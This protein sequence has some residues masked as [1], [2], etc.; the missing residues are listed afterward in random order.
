MTARER[1]S[2]GQLSGRCCLITGAAGALGLATVRRFAA[3]GAKIVA[4]DRVTPDGGW[5]SGVIAE[6]GDGA[7]PEFISD[8]AARH[9][10]LDTLVTFAA[11]SRGGTTE[12]TTPETWLEVLQVN[13][14]ATAL[15]IG[16][17][18]P[19]M[20]AAGRG[21]I[22][23]VGSQ[24]AQSGAAGN[25]SYIASK[26]AVAALTRAVAVENA[27]RGIRCNCLIPGAIESPLLR[28]SFAR[29][30]DP[31]TVESKSLAR[32]PAGRFGAP[33]EVAAA[34]LFLAS[35]ESSFTTGALLPVEGGWLAG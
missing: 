25:V 34:A 32:H 21:A 3:E 23:T 26:G 4:V 16:A 22:V 17:L 15:W 31:L 10:G 18:L 6:V 33:E 27:A 30:D 8:V 35:D 11:L 12:D 7:D 5:P 9:D 20:R 29:T 13:V 19:T 2:P 14:V 1:A 28:Q 24:L